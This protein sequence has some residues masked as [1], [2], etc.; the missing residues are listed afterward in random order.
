[1]ALKLIVLVLLAYS[2][3]LSHV[4]VEGVREISKEEDLELEKQLK[5]LNKPAV[6]TIK[7]FYKQRAFDHPLLQNYTFN[8]KMIPS[9]IKAMT[10]ENTS[11]TETVEDMGI[12][13]GSC[14]DGTSAVARTKSNTGL[15]FNGASMSTS[16]YNPYV[17][18]FQYSASQMKIKNGDD[19]IQVGWMVSCTLYSD[20]LTRMFIY[21]NA[22]NSHCYNDR[23]P[24]FVRLHTN[25]PIPLDYA[26]RETS[27]RGG[28]IKYTSFQI[29]RGTYVEWGGEVFGLP[30][31]RSAPMGGGHRPI[32]D[33]NYDCFCAKLQFQKND[34]KSFPDPKGE[35]ETFI[36]NSRYYG[37]DDGGF[38]ADDFRRLIFFGGIGEAT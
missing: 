10:Q 25:P 31:Q 34:E 7:D 11:N 13:E 38:K 2:W 5:L 27:R 20:S 3:F 22:G 21:F 15:K 19:T 23:C 9:I 4:E 30:S 35:I 17:E 14:P 18:P 28:P 33:T 37:V 8:P 26:F 12:T 6:K 1:M 36:D 29:H 32:L 16:L 24:G